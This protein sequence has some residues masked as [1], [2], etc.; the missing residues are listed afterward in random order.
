MNKEIDRLEIVTGEIEHLFQEGV[1]FS[2]EEWA[3][4]INAARELNTIATDPLFKTK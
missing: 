2:K 4:I 3:R 1:V